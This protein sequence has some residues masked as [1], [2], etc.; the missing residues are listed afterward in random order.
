MVQRR[1]V[2]DR[3]CELEYPREYL[4]S[5]DNRTLC[6][7][8]C[9]CGAKTLRT[10]KVNFAKGEI[11]RARLDGK[12]YL[13]VPVIM[14][15]GDTVMNGALVPASEF[16]TF[17]WNGVP[18]TLRHPHSDAGASITANTPDAIEAFAIGRIF[19]T[20]VVDGQLR[21]EAWVDIL[22]ANALMPG[23]VKRIEV[24]DQIDVSTGFFADPVASEGE[25]R[26]RTY[27]NTWRNLRPDHLAILPDEVG[28][29]NWDD[30]CG[31][32]A[33]T[34][35][36]IT[37]KV[38]E[39]F[40]VL[41]NAL[42]LKGLPTLSANTTDDEEAKAA[43]EKAKA[44][45]A[46]A[47]KE[48]E[49]E[50][51]P[52][53]IA[54]MTAATV[55]AALKPLMTQVEQMATTIA[56]LQTQ[57]ATDKAALAAVASFAANH[58]ATLEARVIANSKLTAEQAKG[59]DLATLELFASALPAPAPANYGGRPA[60]L[61]PYAN[62]AADKDLAAALAPKSVVAMFQAKNKKAA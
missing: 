52:E 53:E 21:A 59:M 54:A 49:D 28:A 22:K 16:E 6:K 37:V 60:P 24:G 51:K 44:E 1:F 12:E 20:Q 18:V 13:V 62:T 42:G 3:T 29:C 25:S 23:L 47:D 36:K 39:A 9:A 2:I 57:T 11:T 19:N 31:L 41:V 61:A 33:N 15:R 34:K 30:G 5:W 46:K 43:A 40:A 38:Q 45:K 4:I 35:G 14:A 56:A 58:R 26:G 17:A 55:A 48:K 32:R 8:G 10:L 50:M 7:P 27:T